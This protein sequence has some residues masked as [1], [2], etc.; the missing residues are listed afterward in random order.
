MY[1]YSYENLKQILQ[2][3]KGQA[4]VKNLETYYN[5]NYADKPILALKYSYAKL[6]Y[7]DGNRIKFQA[8]Y[9]ERRKRLMILQVL[10]IADDAYI[11]PL[12]DIIA[13]ICDEFTWVVPAHKDIVDLFAAETSMYLAETVY[14]MQERISQEIRNRIYTSIENKIIKNYE[15][16]IF[17]WEKTLQNNWNAVCSCGV[18]LTYLYLFPDRFPL[19]KDRLFKTFQLYLST[20]DEEGYCNEGYS[21]WVYGFGFFCLFFD[22]YEQLTGERAPVLDSEL[23]KKLLRYGQNTRLDKDLF[24]PYADGGSKGE[25]D[26]AI[27]LCTLERMFGVNLYLNEK[28]LYE[29]SFHA[30]GYRVIASL[31]RAYPPK[32]NKIETVFYKN[33]QVFIR[34]NG[35]YVFTVK[36]GNNKEHHNHND[37]GTFA[38][39]QNDKQYVADIG[40]G[41]YTLQYFSN[42]YRYTFFPCSSLSHSVPIVDGNPQEA[43][44]EYRATLLNQ[45]ETSITLDI[46]KAYKDGAEKLIAEYRTEKDGVRVNYSCEGIKEKIVFRFMS[47]MQP[48]IVDNK[49]RIENME[50]TTDLPVCAKITRHDYSGYSGK[51]CVVYSIDYEVS[52]A[53][54]VESSFTFQFQ[55]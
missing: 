11:E 51:A 13:T 50:I 16:N 3:E 36:G 26:E 27:T 12:E 53:G 24:L 40:V 48:Q 25:H 23:I 5:A 20:I 37:V 44:E 31:S 7:V 46:A 15:N 43:G 29:P 2:T 14:V 8:M 45:D 38:I 1:C 32:D 41:E 10:A 30:L 9:F 33:S 4:Y 22:V 42:A 28:K 17:R 52:K 49:V 6:V 54:N 55:S 34:Q 47:V 35:N 39:V 18:G 21:Y 19:V